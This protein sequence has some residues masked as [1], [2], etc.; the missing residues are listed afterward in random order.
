MQRLLI[1]L[2]LLSCLALPLA[3]NAQQTPPQIPGQKDVRII[4]DISGSMKQ[5]DP[6]NLRQPA[7]RLLA[8]L[9]P[10]NTTAGV[11]TFGQYV[12]MLVSHGAVNE[13]WR[14]QA[15]ESSTAINSVA[16]RTN[17]GKALEVASDGYYT[18]GDL[19]NT[20]FILLTDGKV[21]ISEDNAVNDKERERVIHDVLAQLAGAGATI[22]TI[23]LSESA[24]LDLLQAFADQTGGSFTLAESADDLNLAFLRSL[25]SAVPQEQIPI[26]GNQFLVDD[27][28]QEFTALIFP[29]Q[30]TG[31]PQQALTL[32]NP[33]GL[34]QTAGGHSVTTFWVSEAGYDLITVTDPPAGQ[35]RVSGALGQGS[36]VTVVSDLKMV[37]SPLPS[38][39]TEQEPVTIEAMFYE[40]DEPV[41]DADFLGVIEVS[42][43]LTS[44][45]GRS[46]SKTLSPDG[47]PTDGIYRDQITRLPVSGDFTLEVLANGQ[48]FSRKFTQT[49]TFVVPESATDPSVAT[50][51]PG[52]ETE[53]RGDDREAVSEAVAEVPDADPEPVVAVIAPI[54]ISAVE[55]PEAVEPTIDDQPESDWTYWYLAGGIGAGL[56][57]V[58]VGIWLWRRR[59]SAD[60]DDAS[61]ASATSLVSPLVSPLVTPL[62]DELAEAAESAPA[63][64]AEESVPDD[65]APDDNAESPEA[66]SEP[67]NIPQLD[68]EITDDDEFGLEDFDLSDIE[69]FDDST[70][71]DDGKERNEG[72][73]SSDNSSDSKTP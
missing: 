73:G 66:E 16:L 18:H 49:L 38:R 22:H 42:V 13:A 35:W 41:T 50:Q 5:T 27:G 36:Q 70:L 31:D 15:A 65:Q 55:V 64:Q 54:D 60:A 6:L 29:G 19:S 34:E 62:A 58:G 43:T 33:E 56:G 23:A 59:S 39:F 7:V 4:V 69:E 26:E 14:N 8:R 30:R 57:V 20:H 51:P 17:L 61:E 2:Y 3:G 48:T 46:G 32:V 52:P 37:L 45:D 72:K 40:D 28:V 67:E 71:N 53:E 10:E 12:N 1:C 21:D 44:P 24:D 25:N 47:P 9:L 11:W 68:D 63:P